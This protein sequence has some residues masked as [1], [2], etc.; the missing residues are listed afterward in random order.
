MEARGMRSIAGCLAVASLVVIQ[1]CSVTCIEDASGTKCT[2]KSLKRFDGA[3]QPP[4]LLDRTPGSPV[5]IDV[6]Y[7][8][9]LVQRSASGKVEVQFLPF[10]YAGYDEKASADQQLSQNLRTS[11]TAQGAVTVNVTREGGSNGLGADTIV[12]LPDNFDGA[13]TILNRGGGPI[14]NFD[15]KV[16]FVGAASALHVT[17]QSILGN[18]WIQGAPS[19]RS[20]TVQCGEDISVFDVGDELNINNTDT[21]HDGDT[22]AITLRLSSISPT[23]RGGRVSTAS[24]TIAATFPSAGGYVINAKSPV[25]GVVQEGGLPGGCN[26]QEASPSAKT[27]SCGNGPSYEL[28][29]GAAPDYIG[30]PKDNNVL[31][32]YQ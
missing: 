15:L 3:P 24:G 6:Y 28:V 5:T 29:A 20:T 21:S 16:E 17:N 7:G 1:G 2:A 4:Q 10:V 23:G 30:Q 19:V 31:L 14:N 27:I 11:A 26:K 9:V 13:L 8:N 22:P 18:C 32:S 12:R 25:K